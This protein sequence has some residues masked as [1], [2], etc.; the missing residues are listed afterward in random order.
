M[1]Q[2]LSHLVLLWACHVTVY[3]ITRNHF[4]FNDRRRGFQNHKWNTIVIKLLLFLVSQFWNFAFRFGNKKIL[5]TITHPF[6]FSD[7]ISKTLMFAVVRE[8]IQFYV[9]FILKFTKLYCLWNNLGLQ[10][11]E[12]SMQTCDA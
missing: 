1:C 4:I 3:I 11:K 8:Q 10:K 12:H 9:T 7:Y 2:L 6:L 5:S